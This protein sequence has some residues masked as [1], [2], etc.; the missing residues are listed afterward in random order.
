MFTS[1]GLGDHLVES[2]RRELFNEMLQNRSPS[3]QD[4]FHRHQWA[5][6]PH[7]SVCMSRPDARTV[8]HTR[9]HVTPQRAT[10]LYMPD[11]PNQPV[12]PEIQSLDLRQLE[13]ACT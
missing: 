7:L 13:P 11:A 4:A 5:D 1:S 8:S 3:M 9:I 12:Q 2:P 10:M 6:R